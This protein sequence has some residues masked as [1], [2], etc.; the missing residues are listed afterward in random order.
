MQLDADVAEVLVSREQIAARVVELPEQGS[1]DA[2][3]QVSARLGIARLALAAGDA[4]AAR[5]EV[6]RA[7]ASDPA[8]PDILTLLGR[9]YASVQQWDDALAA[10]DR[11]L[12]GGMAPQRGALGVRL[13]QQV[14]HLQQQPEGAKRPIGRDLR[15]AAGTPRE[16]DRL[17]RLLVRARQLGD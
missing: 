7:L 10:Y 3:V 12:V 1:D 6:L 11:A 15:T 5:Q 13:E 16:A 2:D 4:E 14:L 9:V 17:P 8:R